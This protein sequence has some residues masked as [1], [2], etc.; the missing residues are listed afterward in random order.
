VVAR[1]L[2]G[3]IGLLLN[4]VSLPV[5]GGTA[6]IFGGWCVLLVVLC[7]GPGPGVLAA[8]L[9]YSCTLWTWG[10][11]WGLLVFVLEA[12]LVG[13]A[14]RHRGWSPA[15]AIAGYWLLVGGPLAAATIVGVHQVPFP[16][17]WAIVLKYP[18][19]SFL[20]TMIAL[21]ILQ[22]RSFRQW[23]GLPLDH[24][25]GK[26]LLLVLSQRYGNVI[27]LSILAL[28]LVVG[29]R[30]DQQLR[31]LR[32]EEIVSHTRELA[33]ELESYL[34]SN[35][36]ALEVLADTLRHTP[37]DDARAL[38]SVVENLRRHYP[39]FLTALVADETGQI[40]AASPA[41]NAEGVTMA[42][43]G[44][45]VKD[46]D[47]FQ[48]PMATGQP[49]VS[50]VFR[51]RG[52]G[53][54]LIVAMSVAVL[55]EDGRPRLVLEG[56]LDVGKLADKDSADTRLTKRAL[57]ITDE[58]GRVV[59]GREQFA[60]DE[61]GV[62][63]AEPFPLSSRR[64][65]DAP[66]FTFDM[67]NAGRLERFIAAS[68]VV[69]HYGWR[70]Y[71][72]E[73]VWATQKIIAR[74]YVA[75]AVWSVVTMALALLMS[76]A[77]SREIT[78]PLN[79][80]VQAVH[81]LAANKAIAVAAPIPPISREL[82]LIDDEL[83][84]ATRTLSESNRQLASAIDQRDQSHAEL[85]NLLVHLEDKVR[86]RTLQLEEARLHAESANAAKSEFL[87]SMSHELRTPLNVILGMS[88]L[89][90]EGG[91]G[92]L[93]PRQ[94]ES[95]RHIRESGQHL[96]ALITD[97]L[98]L[99]KVE[100]G[101]LEL[102]VSSTNVHD[103]CEASMRFVRESARRKELSL[104][105][106]YEF[107]AENMM[108]DA[109]R[110]KQIL[111]NLLSNAVKFTPEGGKI[112]LIVRQTETPPGMEFT[113]WDT[114]I[115]IAETD[116][117]KLFKPFQQIDS[118][119]SRQ[120]AGTGLGLALVRRMTELH[121]GSVALESAPGRGSRFTVRL[122]LITEHADPAVTQG[123]VIARKISRSPFTRPLRVLIAEDNEANHELYAGYLKPR[124][125]TIIA[126]GNGKEAIAH[127][128]TDAPDIVLMDIH[129]PVMDGLEAMQR[130]RA[131]PRTAHLP[132]IAVTALAMSGDQAK[133]LA[134][135]ANAYVTKP[136]NLRELGRLMTELSRPEPSGPPT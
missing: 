115:G 58:A 34:S 28:S 100:A 90:E 112:G 57:L 108:A 31:E 72:A 6:I 22:L 84:S 130:L 35:Q 91:L 129:M 83:R 38:D 81:D 51:G 36:R 25:R 48:Q 125:H 2:G 18:T 111:V 41:V 16:G 103:V 79:K 27:A 67:E 69:P 5:F 120:Y 99:S 52:F 88:D 4:F 50:Q 42:R 20:M 59:A 40:I 23:V 86:Q 12:G 32:R 136:V 70:L 85:Q 55:G 60:V 47:Y 116:R 29:R 89:I 77:I 98:D 132:I 76:R 14:V 134:A 106:H 133:C 74:Y 9:A 113:V 101:M 92:P 53:H 95:V 30:F 13:W 39:G 26:P 21:P 96:L 122:P 131:D 56:S 37:V 80:L 33:L 63:K 73:P 117:E 123:I 43:N 1:P 135:G 61:A 54:D 119:L 7:F 121:G 11:P 64:S 110:L 128:L 46:R 62:L 104:E 109:R 87:A 71:L 82:S 78:R 126:V 3:A 107:S 75:T 124:G 66:D 102:N 44:F 15:A 65:D 10:H 105:T 127:A 49:Y 19:N 118:S 8:L 114:G 45:F 97:I 94:L 93:T 17:N 68:H 24:Q